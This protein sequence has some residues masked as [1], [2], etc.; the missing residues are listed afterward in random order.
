MVD[1]QPYYVFRPRY[2]EDLRLGATILREYLDLEAQKAE[3]VARAKA[4]E[5]ANA[6]A[7]AERVNYTQIFG[8]P[9]SHRC[10]SGQVSIYRRQEDKGNEG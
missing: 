7:A 8:R 1:F 5:K 2:M 10:L 6:A 3:R 9:G 4:N